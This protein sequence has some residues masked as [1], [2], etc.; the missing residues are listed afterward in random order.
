MNIFSVSENIL[1]IVDERIPV[2]ELHSLFALDQPTPVSNVLKRMCVIY[3]TLPET[4]V[5]SRC[6]TTSEL[7]LE[8]AT[9]HAITLISYLDTLD[10]TKLES[11]NPQIKEIPFIPTYHDELFDIFQIPPKHFVAPIE[12]YKFQYHHLVTPLYPT[13]S[14]SVQSFTCLSLIHSPKIE[15][16]FQILYYLIS[17]V[18]LIKQH[19][20]AIQDKVLQVY[21]YLSQVDSEQQQNLIKPTLADC[22]WIWHPSNKQFYAS[23]QVILS[24]LF[25]SLPENTYLVN[26]PYM[27]TILKDIKLKTFLTDVG[28]KE[29]IDD[30]T[31]VICISR[32]RNNECSPLPDNLVQLILKLIESISSHEDCADTI[33]VL[34]RSNTLKRPNELYILP[35][36]LDENITDDISI[37]VHD[38]IHPKSAF[39]L[40]VKLSEE[41]YSCESDINEEDFGIEEE[42]TDRI[43]TLV[44]ELP[45]E[46]LIK[47]LI[48]NAE[49][50]GATEI[51]FILDE[52][53]YSSHD[54]TLSLSSEVYPNWKLLHS[55]PSL[56]VFNNKGFS[57][58]DIKGIQKL[59]VGGKSNDQN[60][61]GKFGLGF[62]SV[63]HITDAPTFITHQSCES[64]LNLCCFDPFLKY[65]TSNWKSVQKKR[66]KSFRIEPQ[67]FAKFADQLFPFTF[68]KFRDVPILGS[69]L[70]NVWSN[71]DYSMFRFPLDIERFPNHESSVHTKFI[72]YRKAESRKHLSIEDVEKMLIKQIDQSSE[73]LLFLKHVKSL[74]VV[75]IERSKKVSLLCSQSITVLEETCIPRP[76]WFPAGNS[77]N[78]IVHRTESTNITF[79]STPKTCEWLTYFHPGIQIQ[80]YVKM[81]NTMSEYSNR[82]IEE[83]LWGFGGIAV[84]VSSRN[85]YRHSNIFNFLPVGSSVN[86]PV[87]VNAPLF[88]DSS[89]QNVHYEQSD[90]AKAWHK[91]IIQFILSPL[92]SLLLVELR[93]PNIHITSL[94]GKREYFNW[95]YSLFPRISSMNFLT[96]LS[97]QIYSFLYTT[98]LPL[99]LAHNLDTSDQVIWYN[100]HDLNC[101]IFL[102]VSFFKSSS[103]PEHSY[104]HPID[105]PYLPKNGKEGGVK[106]KTKSYQHHVDI[107]YLSKNEKERQVPDENSK[108]NEIRRS[109]VTINLP[110]TFAPLELIGRFK[111]NKITQLDPCLLVAYLNDNLHG[112]FQD[113]DLPRNLTYSI[114]SF[115]Q[116][117]TILEYVLTAESGVLDTCDVPIRI[118]IHGNFRIF[119]KCKPC[120]TSR[121]AALLP[122]RSKKF[123]STFYSPENI[124]KL[125]SLGFVDKIKYE[126]LAKHLSVDKF[127]SISICC[128]LFWRFVRSI[129]L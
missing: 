117:E 102:P 33:Y 110:L 49:D 67:H 81:D 113:A 122:H 99:F 71:G 2:P 121:Y 52:Q 24:N 18:A 20:I 28:I 55:F 93:S 72:P 25:Q 103:F 32:I 50:S 112:L 17:K 51:V 42:I 62:N 78:I 87:H 116:L 68:E 86:F 29:H 129:R 45:V 124:E 65:T 106:S 90:L 69:C 75:K 111:G 44:R 92:Y 26:F 63:Y 125:V 13:A 77:Q 115:K 98:N 56:T 9:S 46:S 94:D 123:I 105:I 70:S 60:S 48:Q 23:N 21:K 34:S 82:L 120:F 1:K 36:T 4:E 118:D 107:P 6:E 66:G 83:K 7:A 31:I 74:K 22:Q 5:V 8:I 100:I 64:G 104:Q 91:S 14:N 27:E 39:K 61:I 89:R 41:L 3:D 30:E 38:R 119:K 85:H 47:E 58:E 127:E 126:Y 88:I 53:D 54:K 43:Q 128:P 114:L 109:L 15:V 35:I 12:C 80:E 59:S 37:F 57:K 10:K 101:G 19:N 97:Q 76:I 73:I 96:E 79:Q 84:C 108:E 95:F 40:G 11:I 16:V